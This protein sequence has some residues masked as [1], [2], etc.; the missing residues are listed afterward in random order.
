[1]SLGIVVPAY[2][3]DVDAL[4]GY[5]RALED[6]LSPERIRI[7]SDAADPETAAALTDL[8]GAFDAV[9][10]NAV[11]DRRGKGAAVTA[12]FE[13]LD[14]SVL[15]FVDADGATPVESA[16]DVIGPVRRGAVSVAVGS[17]RHPDADV[18]M[19]QGHLRRFL[20]DGF[21][22]L[23]RRV[24]GSTGARLYDYQCG[25]KALTAEVWRAVRDHLHQPGFAWDLEFVAVAA[26][27]GYRVREVPITWED[28]PGSTVA[29]VRDTAAMF[30]G[31]LRARHRAGIVSGSA[32]HRSIARDPGPP[33]VDRATDPAGGDRATDRAVD[34]GVDGR[35][36]G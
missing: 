35:G 13:A 26:A 23:A 5:V 3:P 18:T 8:A 7:E 34:P 9:S 2:R 14:T 25:A 22:W 24:V 16:V 27:C 28:K 20:G 29:P 30:A 15:A 11:P 33:L 12:G 6:R 19:H 10:V 21:A 4:R 17:R 36:P 1:M 31:L 32:V